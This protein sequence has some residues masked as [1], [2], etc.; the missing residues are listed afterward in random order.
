MKK[1]LFFWALAWLLILSG[2]GW[3]LDIQEYNN[4]FVSLVKDCTDSTQTL[5]QNFEAEWS[6]IDTIKTS[7]QDCINICQESQ[8]KA[9]K[10][11]DY[12]WDSSLKDAVVKL[13]SLET[14]YLEKF[15]ST[16]PYW[17][18]DDI[19]DEDRVQYT[20]SVNE[21]QQAE[22]LLNAQFLSLQEV[23]EVFAAN[24][25]LKLETE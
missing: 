14:Q 25:K 23:Q 18:I 5:F 15:W 11:W 12:Q 20:A 16:S 22:E 10:M 1:N 4:S 13:L 2:C 9:S 6:T 24:H 7:L 21:L 8:T 17:N 3:S 19:T